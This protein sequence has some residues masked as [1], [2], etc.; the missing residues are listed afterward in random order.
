MRKRIV[1]FLVTV[2]LVCGMGTGHIYAQEAPVLSGSAAETGVLGGPDEVMPTGCRQ[3]IQVDLEPGEIPEI[4]EAPKDESFRKSAAVYQSVWDSYS[5]NYYYNLLGDAERALW[6]KLDQMCLGYLAGT[7]TLTSKE[8]YRNSQSGLDFD[9]YRT[10]GVV[11]SGLNRVQAHNTLNMFVFSN[12]QYYFLQSLSSV[13]ESG[14]S[15]IAVLTV[16]ES[17]ANG[18]KRMQE[19][20]KIQAVIQDWMQQINAEPTVLLK[21]KKIHDMICK[22]VTYDMDY[23]T[24]Q[25]NPYNQTIYSVFFTDTTVCAGYSQAMQLL[26]NAAGI[27][28]AVVTSEE[29]EWNIVR[30]NGTWYYVDCTWDDNVADY[31]GW[32]SSYYYFNRSLQTYM[33]DSNKQNVESHITEPMWNGLLPELIYDSGATETDYG[34]IFTPSSALLPPQIAASDDR[35]TITSPSG[36]TIYYTTD[37]SEP[38]VAS[39]RARRYTGAIVLSA[40]TRIRAVAV[41][42]ACIDSAI[43][44]LTVTPQYR[45]TLSANGGYIGKKGVTTS[46]RTIISGNTLGK[47]PDAKRKG[48]AFLGWYTAK[49]GGSKVDAS[50]NVSASKTYYARWAKIK[51]KKAF[52]S[53]ARNVSGKAIKLKIKKV[54][55]ASG[56]QLRYSANK[57][58]SGSKKKETTETTYTIKKLK[59]GK[60]YYVQVR[61]FQKDSVS[62]KKTYGPWSKAKSVKIKK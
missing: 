42:N 43:S 39:P 16:N 33:N 10:K 37:G 49:S 52:L 3:L 1:S 30:L 2:C 20:A 59:K 21:E 62:G 7:E 54:N 19:T 29:H 53:S 15:G 60:T 5:T 61:M 24:F 48:Y 36:G 18:A 40:V 27:D 6:D 8:H 47:L 51:K 11:F 58:M 57:N 17:F 44:E 4:Y 46:A 14:G 32:D 26:C 13:S 34:T 45:V 22:K 55:T 25:Q 38:S 28:C 31:N 56:Y 12:P 35:V 41:A 50:L 9:Y 23:N